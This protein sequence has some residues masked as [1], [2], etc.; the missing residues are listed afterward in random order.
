MQC[1]Q[2]ITTTL[3]ESRALADD[4]DNA[5]LVFTDYG[6][7]HMKTWFGA[8]YGK[9][10]VEKLDKAVL[11]TQAALAKDRNGWLGR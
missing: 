1:Q 3:H 11:E 10:W 9:D 2:L 7:D 8:K 5:S 6:K 4:I